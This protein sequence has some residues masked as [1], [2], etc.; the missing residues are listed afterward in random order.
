MSNRGYDHDVSDGDGADGMP[1][2]AYIT[3]RIDRNA[4]ANLTTASTEEIRGLTDTTLRA[5]FTDY[6]QVHQPAARSI[7]HINAA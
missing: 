7:T 4:N 2:G 5:R 3:P 6:G 1:D